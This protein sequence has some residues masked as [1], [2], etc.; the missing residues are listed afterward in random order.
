MTIV[1][2]SLLLPALAAAQA[3]PDTGVA[4]AQ[5]RAAVLVQLFGGGSPLTASERAA[6]D[7]AVR[8]TFTA[9]P[10]AAQAAATDSAKMLALV[11][12]RQGIEL[13]TAVQFGRKAIAFSYLEALSPEPVTATAA[14]IVAAHDPVV[15]QDPAKQALVTMRTV[16]ALVAGNRA[17]SALFKVPGPGPTAAQILAAEIRKEW[18]NTDDGMRAALTDAPRDLPFA[19]SFLAQSAPAARAKFIEQYH[20]TILEGE[21]PPTQ[22]LRLAEVMAFVGQRGFK[23]RGSTSAAF[24]AMLS[25]KGMQAAMDSAGRSLMSNCR[26]TAGAVMSPENQRFCNPSPLP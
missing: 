3:A 1:L 7:S 18:P 22:Q 5:A 4:A 10:T 25:A 23:T 16:D 6:L 8:Q 17:G 12:G 19:A 9:N 21:N 2:A 20:R 13:E 11:Q 15:A 24:N 26:V 14:R